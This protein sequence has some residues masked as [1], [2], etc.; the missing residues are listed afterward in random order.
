MF[1]RQRSRGRLH[2]AVLISSGLSRQTWRQ[3]GSLVI[4]MV[5]LSQ[6]HLQTETVLGFI[7]ETPVRVETPGPVP[8]VLYGGL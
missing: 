4:I 5:I 6:T 3:R 2:L 7:V 8:G 1:E